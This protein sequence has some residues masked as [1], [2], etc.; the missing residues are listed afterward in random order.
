MVLFSTPGFPSCQLSWLFAKNQVKIPQM[1]FFGNSW[2]IW[3]CDMVISIRH[4]QCHGKVAE[5]IPG[6]YVQPRQFANP[7]CTT[8][9]PAFALIHF[10]AGTSQKR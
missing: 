10:L 4:T 9:F 6:Q 8:F 2:L 7:T 1:V 5:N 3:E